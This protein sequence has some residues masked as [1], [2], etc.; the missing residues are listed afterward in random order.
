MLEGIHGHSKMT[1]CEILLA[2]LKRGEKLTVLTALT[3]YGVYALSQ[4]CTD[5]R[6]QGWNVVSEMITLPNGKRV[7]QYRFPQYPL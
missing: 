5:L 7:A 2:A 1:Q 3:D 4:R 6:R